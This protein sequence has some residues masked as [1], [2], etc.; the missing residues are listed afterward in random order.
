M[1]VTTISTTMTTEVTLGSSG[2]PLGI[3]IT[4]SGAIISSQDY[5]VL[6]GPGSYLT[7]SGTISGRVFGVEAEYAGVYNSGNIYG[8]DY[9]LYLSEGSRLVNSGSID[10]VGIW[11]PD[12]APALVTNIVNAGTISGPVYAIAANG[13]T[14]N[15]TVDPGAVFIGNVEAE[16]GGITLA[17]NGAGSLDVSNFSGFRNISFVS[18]EWTLEGGGLEQLTNWVTINGF[19]PG[20]TLV[21][22]NFSVT[23]KTYSASGALSLTDGNT[24]ETI[25][26]PGTFTTA[27]FQITDNEAGGTDISA[28]CYLPGTRILTQAGECLVEDLQ[29]G[30]R[31]LTRF[32]GF[33]PIKWI[34][35]Q[36]YAPR[37][38]SRDRLPVHIAAGALGPNMPAGALR[39]SP[40][41][42]MLVGNTLLLA[43]NLINGITIMQPKAS[44]TVEY[45]AIELE[46]HDCVLAN[47]AWGESFAD[48]P[49]L[50]NQFHNRAEFHALFPGYIEPAT[51]SLCAPRPESG[52]ELERALLPILARFQVVPGPLRGYIDMLGPNEVVGWALDEAHPNLP[53]SM[54]ICADGRILGRALACHYRADLA[55]AR[56]GRGNC[57]FLFAL[58]DGISTRITVRRTADGA[59]IAQTNASHAAVA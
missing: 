4:N 46:R 5:G 10:G 52:P 33:Q 15:L 12:L 40:G 7:N 36:S 3:S 58:P 18:G 56:L 24:Y 48:G 31:V 23:D 35:R 26:L 6:G 57:M 30:D 59:E 27:D 53:V 1:A 55:E 49:G 14:L 8:G 9:G 32:S 19:M 28:L 20:D 13:E 2:D 22:D 51:L 17:G 16:F 39:V 44:E 25:D 54:E 29:L 37:F 38:M 11:V 43:K 42:S 41:H 21:L 50:R 34:G 47:H 45:Y